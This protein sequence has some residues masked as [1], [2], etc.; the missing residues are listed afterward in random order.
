MS[1]RR[2]VAALGGLVLA[3]TLSVGPLASPASAA[4]T[5]KQR[6]NCNVDRNDW[7]KCNKALKRNQYRYKVKCYDD[8][9]ANRFTWDYGQWRNQGGSRRSYATCP[10]GDLFAEHFIDVRRR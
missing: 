3:G 5:Q 8:G 4:L 9:I 7:A 6:E 1:Y 10:S 2:I